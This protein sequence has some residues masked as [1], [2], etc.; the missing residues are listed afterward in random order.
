MT[1]STKNFILLLLLLLAYQ[2]RAQEEVL[3]STYVKELIQSINPDAKD[4][5]TLETLERALYVSRSIKFHNGEARSLKL[6]ADH[7]Q[8]KGDPITALRLNLQLLDKQNNE[9]VNVSKSETLFQ[10]ANIYGEE[11]LGNKALEYYRELLHLSK[12]KPEIWLR[13]G[14]TFLREEQADSAQFYFTQ[15]YKHAVK[16][17]DYKLKLYSLQQRILAGQKNKQHEEVLKH[18][19]EILDLVESSG[20]DKLLATCFNNLG[21]N[22]HEIKDYDS[23]MI[24][25]EKA[26]ALNQNSSI[27]DESI[28][29]TNIGI[30][31]Q[32]LGNIS[33]AIKYFSMARELLNKSKE[34][35]RYVYTTHLMATAYYKNGD[36]FNA[37]LFNEKAITAAKKSAD[38]TNLSES[39]NLGASIHQDLYDYEKALTFY[40]QHLAL[41][42]SF[43]LEDRIRQQT[44]L[45]QKYLLE[46]A[47]KE[48]KILI[49]N[50][51]IQEL[52]LNQ[53]NLEK[54]K[55][56]LSSEALRLEGE[57]RESELILLRKEQ[58]IQ[59]ASLKNK[60]LE[61]LKTQQ[62]LLLTTQQLDAEKQERE[63]S[64]LNRK[65]AE[66]RLALTQ[67]EAE[68]KERNKEIDLLNKDKELLTRQQEIAQLEI[69]KQSTFRQLV[70]G[71]SAL[72]LLILGLVLAGLIFARRANKKL[73][74]K[75]VEIESQKNEIEKN[76]DLIESEKA[77]SDAL[78]LNILPEETAKELR[79]NG[80][81][82]P[83]KY[84]LA[85]VLF[86]DFSGF[87]RISKHMSAEKLI[88]EL[89]ECFVAFDEIVIRHGLEKIKTIGDSYMCAGGLPI[90]N[91]S[92]P[93][94]IVKAAQE[95]RSFM[96]KQTELKKSENFPY[97]KM[98][99]GIHTGA[100]IAGVVGK[101]K[102]AYDIWGDT[103]NIAS[104][105]E[106]SGEEGKINISAATYEL[107]KEDFQ[108]IAR[109]AIEVKNGG[110]VEMYFVN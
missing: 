46:R 77:K 6:L 1:N 72:A 90:P 96:E 70:Y 19:L 103:V 73:E 85:S 4:E 24:Y 61:A 52:N 101:Q 34:K 107:V 63:I 23:A 42:D 11:N 5:F 14:Q 36:L 81:A 108:C 20:D 100:V 79:E 110:E 109:G 50:Q 93:K 35:D 105:M 99:I 88:N 62:T 64:E 33:K 41:R 87:T 104:R 91:T 47:E 31:S 37:Q 59:E 67:K 60:E 80:M 65:E 66:Q 92:N 78:L 82:T 25:F 17:G 8:S 97:W 84:E 10:I 51:E 68:E 38:K 13:M 55:L 3:D 30:A 40:K 86:T 71:L 83:K 32:N 69:D 89:N 12:D 21:Y 39:F 28:V 22:Y 53:L 7:Y 27:I 58:E 56:E 26:A 9:K 74:Q 18:N 76:K 45:Q 29:F 15:V 98:R 94:D 44:L 106:S 43:L 75:N 54:E 48:I 16:N 2:L 57:K 102:F 95:M 49:S